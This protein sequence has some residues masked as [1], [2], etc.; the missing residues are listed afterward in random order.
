MTHDLK[1]ELVKSMDA[2]HFTQEAKDAMRDALLARM[3]AASACGKN[4]GRKKLLLIALAAALLLA[5]LTGAAVFTR[6]TKSMTTFYG[7]TQE[8]RQQAQNIGLSA[9]LETNADRNEIL[10]ATDQGVTITAVQSIADPYSAQITFRIEGFNLPEGEK[11]SIQIASI[12]VEDVHSVNT[13]G[14][15]F[16][17]TTVNKA[18]EPVYWDGSPLQYNADGSPKL[19]FSA[20]DGSLEY[21][22]TLIFSAGGGHFGKEVEVRFCALGTETQ[23]SLLTGEW[24]LKW[25]LTGTTD[26]VA[27]TPNAPIG[28][29]GITLL[30]AEVTPISICAVFKIDN[31]D[32]HIQNNAEGF[33]PG[34]EDAFQT[35]ESLL[36]GIRTK[37]GTIHTDLTIN[38]GFSSMLSDE[39]IRLLY[40]QYAAE[41][42]EEKA[43]LVTLCRSTNRILEPNKV[44]AYMFRKSLP[45]D[46]E[47]DFY[48]VPIH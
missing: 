32:G 33:D 45:G 41:V 48:I 8:Q 27:S 25:T 18:G 12:G 2:I 34:R 21:T 17:G 15:F 31:A 44:D 42:L 30:E 20:D 36:A 39:G 1:Q 7:A 14:S 29:T 23:P 37:D 47:D 46:A 5:T 16:D 26:S 38:M 40:P 28:D 10:S 3:A 43:V 6:W 24:T 35:A 22:A 13:H 19:A 4:R 11:P 9:N